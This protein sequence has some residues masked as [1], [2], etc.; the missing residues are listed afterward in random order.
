MLVEFVRAE[1]QV[2]FIE[3]AFGQPAKEAGHPV[4]Q[5]IAA[6]AEDRRRRVDHLSEREKVTLC[7]A[8][9][10]QKQEDRCT[11]PAAG[12]E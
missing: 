1:N 12:L 2:L 10:V 8:R 6:H 3:D 5:D 7:P 9:S 11:V 4:F